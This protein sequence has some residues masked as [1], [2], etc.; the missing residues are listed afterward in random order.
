MHDSEDVKL[1]LAVSSRPI[2]EDSHE[3]T[4]GPYSV[5]GERSSHEEALNVG[6]NAVYRLVYTSGHRTHYPDSRQPITMIAW[7]I[8]TGSSS[9]SHPTGD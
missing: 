1:L 6:V 5:P 8:L 9:K 7:R 4:I 3:I 2:M